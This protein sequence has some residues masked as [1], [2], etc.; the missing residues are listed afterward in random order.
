MGDSKWWGKIEVLFD[1]AL[2]HPRGERRVWLARASAGNEALR[3]E[4]EGMLAAHERTM[5]VL[6]AAP[7]VLRPDQSSS[8]DRPTQAFPS[9]FGAVPGGP[10]VGPYRVLREIGRG[11]MGVVYQAHDP[12]L[13]RDVALKFLPRRDAEPELMTRFRSE[14]KAASAL[15][16]PNICTIH[17]IGETADGLLYI[18]MAFYDGETLAERIARGP[19][20]VDEAVEL[21]LQA[22]A[23]LARAHEDG[24]VHRDVKPSNL[25]VTPRP[26]PDRVKI[27]DFGIAKL[28]GPR[29]TEPGTTPGT[30]AY[31]APE[32]LEGRDADHRADIWSLGVVIYETLA[33]ELPFGAARRGAVLRAILDDLPAPLRSLRPEVPRSLERVVEKALS[34]LPD[35]RHASVAE[36]IGELENVKRELAGPAATPIL[37][38]LVAVELQGEDPDTEDGAARALLREHGGR[39]L[40]GGRRPGA[41]RL[42]FERPWNAVSWALACQRDLEKRHGARI[43]I[44]LAEVYHHP[45]GEPRSDAAALDLA[46][47]LAALARDRQTLLTRGAFD[48][49]RQASDGRPSWLAHGA[50]SLEQSAEPVEVFEAGEAGVAPL[51]PPEGG[52][53]AHQDAILGWRPAAGQTLASRPDWR[54]DRKLGAGG[55]GEVWLASS[56]KTGER[57]AFKF[58]FEARRLRALKREITIFR[59][60]KDEL[61][62]RDDIARIL[63]WNFETE[64]YFIE[65]EYTEDGDLEEWAEEQGGLD[66]ISLEI[67]LAIVAQVAEALSAAHS[68]GV[69]HK[70]VKPSNVLIRTDSTGRPRARLADFGIGLLTDET[71][72]RDS[73]ITLL[74][75]TESATRSEGASSGTP[76]YRA[77]ELLEGKAPT[78][79][80]DVYAL[81]VMLY[82]MVVGDFHRALGPGWE[83]DVDDELLREDIAAAVDKSPRRRL[84]NAVRLSQRLAE[85]AQRRAHR[86]AERRARAEHERS[87]R[88]R[89]IL[90]LATLVLAAFAAAMTWQERRTAREAERAN[91]E[92][93]TARQVADLLVRIFEVS[94]PGSGRGREITAREVLESGATQ[95]EWELRDQPEVRARLMRTIGLVYRSLGL[96]DDAAPLFESAFEIRRKLW[97]EEHP[98]VAESLDDL[99]ELAQYRGEF[100]KAETL[101]REALA[102]RRRLLGE[103]HPDVATSLNTLA[104]VLS[105]RGDYPAA[106]ELHREALTMRRRLLGEEHREVAR[107]LNNLAVMLEKKGDVDTA[108]RLYRE[109]LAMRRNLLGREHPTVAISLSNLA[110]LLKGKGELAA[111][112]ELFR[113]AL[114]IRR[115][116]LGDEHPDLAKSLNALALVLQIRGDLDAAEPL[117]REALAMRRHLLGDEHPDVAT[118][119]ISLGWLVKAKGD[120]ESAEGLYREALAMRRRLLGDEHPRVID[121]LD[122]LAGLLWEIGSYAEAEPLYRE[123]LTTRRREGDDPL[124]IAANL[125]NLAGIL[126]SMGDVGA[127]EPLCREGLSIRR[128]LLDGGQPALARSLS[129]MARLHLSRGDFPTAEASIREALEILRA[130]L[131][132]GH[133]LIAEAESVLGAVLDGLG[134]DAEA[135]ELLLESYQ[136]LKEQKGGQFQAT[137]RAGR[138][139]TDFYEERG[140]GEKA[141]SYRGRT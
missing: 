71:R 114:A 70:D 23:G 45:D 40:V 34:K 9:D 135:E 85:L 48:L 138:Y 130:A 58:C 129:R 60:L 139:L 87:R 49:A 44:H 19:I 17:D 137:E 64:P 1:E 37:M 47:R 24:I 141:A 110:R 140:D 111:A 41:R 27:V 26:G 38:T 7:E 91:Q 79:Q 82:Q 93:E 134:R 13:D 25:M 136:I 125:D 88:R 52:E 56:E 133:W 86:Q 75:L 109:A 61:G 11:G 4:V 81:G 67:R 80:A 123:A 18:A 22:A 50:Y 59:L 46:V 84:G 33:G 102:M 128:R 66:R 6:E 42:V 122:R 15:D 29:L 108:E 55:F 90:A 127:A 14:A 124:A 43:G 51:E 94:D 73:G 83:R 57:R 8:E 65:S 106:E 76:L 115:R 54:L 119:L 63:D 30:L 112:E 98:E 99:A 96:Y 105:K 113:E 20:P 31:M 69:L 117:Y 68:V 39:H 121:L 62:E 107:S 132:T 12:R 3:R 74:G 97:G 32:Q 53:A 116:L 16:H 78:V 92:A 72:L 120:L 126:E 104:L 2:E 10:C 101:G 100:E 89:R 36:L 21:A 95:L 5:G 28:E 103:E 35:E 131:P 77:P 118:S